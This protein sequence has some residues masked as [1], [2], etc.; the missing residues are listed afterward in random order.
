[1]NSFIYAPSSFAQSDPSSYEIQ[2]AKIR[3]CCSGSIH[4]KNQLDDIIDK[5][6]TKVDD[7]VIYENEKREQK[8]KKLINKKMKNRK[9]KLMAAFSNKEE[10]CVYEDLAE[11]E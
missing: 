8:F 9:Q 10:D 1:L 3:Y 11:L 5:F 4:P 2:D 6:V 7:S